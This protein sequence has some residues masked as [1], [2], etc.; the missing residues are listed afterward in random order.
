VNISAFSIERDQASH[1]LTV[2][3]VLHSYLAGALFEVLSDC[4]IFDLTERSWTAVQS[5]SDSAMPALWGASAVYLSTNRTVLI[6]GGFKQVSKYQSANPTSEVWSFALDSGTWTNLTGSILGMSPAPR[7]LAPSITLN[8]H[9]V[10]V[11][12]GCSQVSLPYFLSHGMCEEYLIDQWILRISNRASEL[13]WVNSNTT[14]PYDG[15]YASLEH[16]ASDPSNSLI[17][18][19]TG[20]TQ[21]STIAIFDAV[22][23][24]WTVSN[25]F[26]VPAPAGMIASIAYCTSDLYLVYGGTSGLNSSRSPTHHHIVI[27]VNSI[28]L[29]SSSGLWQHTLDVTHAPRPRFF[30]SADASWNNSVIVFGIYL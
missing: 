26:D 7:G 27:D 2:H 21:L 1:H 15:G 30:S 22:K 23:N 4:W 20:N 5:L 19:F 28:Y 14:V 13:E 9:S 25:S 11:S 8:E 16:L 6:Y 18:Y 10:I 12:A 29:Y 3:V 17:S 24:R